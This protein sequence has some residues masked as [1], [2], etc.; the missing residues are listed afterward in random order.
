[1]QQRMHLYT[2]Q[3]TRSRFP[4]R[5]ITNNNDTSIKYFVSSEC[6]RRYHPECAVEIHS[7]FL[8]TA[9]HR[10]PV[11]QLP[12]IN[13][14]FFLPFR[15]FKTHSHC[16]LLLFFPAL[17]GRLVSRCRLPGRTCFLR[18]V[19]RPPERMPS[20]AITHGALLGA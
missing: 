11:S 7:P 17:C 20:L 1:M 18:V 9:H 13:L 10:G 5:S 14:S 16:G 8:G 15:T 3:Q 19:T 12:M 4:V 6:P 2:G